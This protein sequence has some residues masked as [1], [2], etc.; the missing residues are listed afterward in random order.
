A[1]PNGYPDDGAAVRAAVRALRDRR[2]RPGHARGARV[3]YRGQRAHRTRI[4]DHRLTVANHPR[5]Y[6]APRLSLRGSELVWGSRTYVMGIINATPDSFSGDGIGTDVQAAV[7][8]AREME[9][10]GADWLDIGGESSRPGADELEPAEELRRVLPVIEALR[11][12]TTLPI[13]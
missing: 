9:A 6:V 8:R 1:E 13:S 2:R 12:A 4:R 10:A 7:A 11:A 5:H 3:A